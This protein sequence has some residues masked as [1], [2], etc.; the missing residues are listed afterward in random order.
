MRLFEMDKL[1]EKAGIATLRFGEKEGDSHF[2]PFRQE[3]LIVLPDGPETEFF[4]LL[5]GKQFLLRIGQGNGK[6]WLGGT[7]AG[8]PFLLRL[9]QRAFSVFSSGGEDKFFSAL[10]PDTVIELEEMLGVESIRLGN[11]FATPTPFSWEDVT[12]AHWL[13]SGE[14]L[15]PAEAKEEGVIE[16]DHILQGHVLK[17]QTLGLPRV[18]ASGFLTTPDHD[19]YGLPGIHILNQAEC[20]FVP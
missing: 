12:K 16:S 15:T 18:L 3:E 19:P 13:V 20:L 8:R 11:I 14:D 6:L 7:D 10:K 5:A 9:D 4:E 2:S 1:P 17:V